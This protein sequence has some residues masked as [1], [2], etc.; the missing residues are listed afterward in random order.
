MRIDRSH[1]KWAL[2]AAGGTL[3]AFFFYGVSAWI[4]RVPPSGGSATGIT[5]GVLG[6]GLMLYAAFLSVRKQFP[7]WRIGRA[8]TWMRGHLWLGLLSYP[9]ILL[10]AGFTF[11]GGTL[12]QVTMW[13]FTVVVISG[14]AGAVLQHYMPKV[15][16]REVRVETIYANISA[17]RN[18]LAV[19][20]DRLLM[21]VTPTLALFLSSGEVELKRAAAATLKRPDVAAL[22]PLRN[23]VLEQVMPFLDSVRADHPLADERYANATF[24]QLRKV[25]PTDLTD[26][27]DDIEEICD[28]KRQLDRQQRLHRLLHG[29][30]FVHVPLS[31]AL[32]VLALVHAI[33]ALRY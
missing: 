25:T 18:Q 8:Q 17:V 19:E 23:V 26:L 5:L 16:T 31:Y 33:V 3:A 27:I 12:T 20:A 21:P 9:V 2:G 32:L 10:H 6:L 28:E 7:I 13:I 24:E 4:A 30:L 1:R 14:I 29:W 15:M 11:G 22:K